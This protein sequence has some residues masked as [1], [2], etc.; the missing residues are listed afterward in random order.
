MASKEWHIYGRCR[1]VCGGVGQLVCVCVGAPCCS[2]P[3]THCAHH[4]QERSV[5]L[6]R[7]A[8]QYTHEKGLVSMEVIPEGCS[9]HLFGSV[10]ILNNAA[11]YIDMYMYIFIKSLSHTH[12]CI[13]SCTTLDMTADMTISH[14]TE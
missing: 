4:V 5:P 1:F 6:G 14:D 2:A 3:Q 7:N 11:T 12:T 8:H 10:C 13:S 9:V